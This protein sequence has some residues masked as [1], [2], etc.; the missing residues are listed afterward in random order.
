MEIKT[1][2]NATAF[3]SP[4]ELR[5]YFLK[6]ARDRLIDG[7]NEIDEL[8][9]KLQELRANMIGWRGMVKDLEREVADAS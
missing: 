9:A 7:M 6:N 3:N 8:S 2:I 5:D 1:V 4:G